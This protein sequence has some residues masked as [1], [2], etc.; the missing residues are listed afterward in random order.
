MVLLERPNVEKKGIIVAFDRREGNMTGYAVAGKSGSLREIPYGPE[1]NGRKIV[2]LLLDNAM[3]YLENAAASS[4]NFNAPREDQII[5]QVSLRSTVFLK[6][7]NAPQAI[8]RDDQK[9]HRRV[10][11]CCSDLL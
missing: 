6:P 10:F 5:K 4:I 11:E 3:A 1:E 8:E 9:L 2:S 7:A